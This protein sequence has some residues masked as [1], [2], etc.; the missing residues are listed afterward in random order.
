MPIE[1]IARRRAHQFGKQSVIGTPV[2]A[3]RRIAWKG[4]PDINP[5]WTDQED[6]DTGLID[7]ALP[8]YRVRPDLTAP[9]LGGLASYEDLPLLFAA[10]LRGGVSPTGG[11]TAKTWVFTGLSGTNTDLD[12]F[13]YQFADDVVR[14]GLQMSGG[15]VESWELAW[16]ESQG[17]WT[18]SSDWRFAGV[19]AHVTPTAGLQVGSNLPLIFGADTAVYIDDTSGGIGGTILSDTVHSGSIKVTNE[20][21]IKT[22]SNGSNTR[23]AVP[24]YALVGRTIEATFRFAKTDAIIAALNSETVDWLSADPVT[25]YVKILAQ[26]TALAQASTPYSLDLRLSGTWRTRSEGEIG[27]NSVVELML[28][29]RYDAGLTYP[30]QA[31]VVGQRSSVP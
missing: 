9:G 20:I 1:G 10:G 27:G 6:A 3:T 15:I 12:Y 22:F 28:K 11:G 24:G 25:R 19:N 5:N 4:T 30:I 23:F 16:D 21:D 18:I 2:A 14:D 7:V 26:S 29:G 31:T 17:P 13:T 8:P